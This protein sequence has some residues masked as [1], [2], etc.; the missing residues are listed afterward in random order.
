MPPKIKQQQN[1]DALAAANAYKEPVSKDASS[2]IQAEDEEGELPLRWQKIEKSILRSINTRF[3]E[4]GE[5]LEGLFA[6]QETLGKRVDEVEDQAADHEQ[7][8]QAMETALEEVR[9]QNKALRSKLS[10]LESRSRRNNIKIIGIPEQE[11][12]GRPT[13]FVTNLIPKLLGAENFDKP[14]LIDR[15]HRTYRADN[16]KPR[17]IIAR[18]HFAQDKDKI[19]RIGRQRTLEYAGKRIFIFPDYSADVM[20]QRR[21]FKEVLQALREKNVQHSLRFPARLH[22]SHEGQVKV[23]TNPVEA[24]N[25]VDNDL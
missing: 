15:A 11:E 20:E 8:I 3:N 2:K 5:R 25:F 24:K 13:D 4:F 9:N 22:I 21:G 12:K 7:R 16:T 17:T 6:G 19:I 1:S 10:D 23:F 14:P 18:V